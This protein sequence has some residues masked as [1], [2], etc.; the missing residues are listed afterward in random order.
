MTEKGNCLECKEPLES[1][2]LGL[3]AWQ[4]NKGELSPLVW[5]VICQKHLSEVKSELTSL[6][7]LD[8]G[9]VF[10]INQ[11]TWTMP[12]KEAYQLPH[13]RGEWTIG[14][15]SERDAKRLFPN[16]Y[17]ILVEWIDPEPYAH[18]TQGKGVR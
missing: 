8:E 9:I 2:A 15:L 11:V 16:A 7:R 4:Y 6:T 3:H 18:I 12:P 10:E 1:K 5:H 17:P 14:Y 13:Y